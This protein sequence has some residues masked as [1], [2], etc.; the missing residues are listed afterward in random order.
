MNSKDRTQ[1]YMSS[2]ISI[3]KE[4]KVKRRNIQSKR[5]GILLRVLKE[6]INDS[7][8]RWH[9]MKNMNEAK[10]IWEVWFSE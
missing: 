1:N 8:I 10:N 7:M 9:L 6:R 4:K 2:G 3:N 5:Y